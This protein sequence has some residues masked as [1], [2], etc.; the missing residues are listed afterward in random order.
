MTIV[1]ML[2]VRLL[3]DMDGERRSGDIE[4]DPVFM[5]INQINNQAIKRLK[6][7]YSLCF[8]KQI[9]KFICRL[10]EQGYIARM[11]GD[12]YCLTQ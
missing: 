7:T 9:E 12:N 6:N 10:E 11:D 8:K 2:V 3:T 4:Y 1:E 5:T